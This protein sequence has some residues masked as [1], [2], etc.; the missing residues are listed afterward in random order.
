M[1]ERSYSGS[2]GHSPRMDSSF[3]SWRGL[4][5]D[6]E[7]VYLPS[8]SSGL[9]PTLASLLKSLKASSSTEKLV[10][11]AT[12]NFE[13]FIILGIRPPRTRVADGYELPCGFWEPNLGFLQGAF[14][15]GPCL[16]FIYDL[17]VSY[18]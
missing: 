10:S 2:Q 7:L 9:L 13:E 8:S 4:E 1:V 14:S 16:I 17:I 12:A 3:E 5:S 18:K 15:P 11:E 6:Y